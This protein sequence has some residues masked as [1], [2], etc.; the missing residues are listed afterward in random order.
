MKALI[1]DNDSP[2]SARLVL[3]EIPQPRPA[4]GE[5]LVR[6][7]AAGLNR[8]DLALLKDHYTGNAIG[9]SEMAGVVV[10][11]AGCPGYTVGDR[12][13]ALSK[14]AHAEYACVDHRLAVHVPE[15]VDWPTAASL[16][17][18][19]MTAHDAV[20]TQG[21][22]CAGETVLVQG[23][24]SGVGQ[25][26]ARLARLAG[27][28]VVIGAGRSAAKLEQLSEDEVTHRLI[29][30]GDWAARAQE[31]TTGRGVDLVIDMVGGGSLVG[32]LHSLAVR[33]RIVAVGRLG[34]QADMLDIG[35]LAHKRAQLIGVTFRTR[36][37]DE[38]SQIARA[39]A[40]AVLPHV[41]AGRIRPRLD[42]I[43]PLAEIAAAQELM[44]RNEHFG[45]VVLAIR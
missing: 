1:V 32:N 17:A 15:N 45:K 25:A 34:G 8:A 4:V 36:S 27:A 19:Y 16:P 22:L 38:K 24:T 5:L 23:V 26:A 44:R 29:T 37:I 31:L 41:V 10:E 28:R 40:D 42:R 11:A 35:M 7:E 30:D 39:F 13:M 21:R 43:Y 9:G 20:F 33:G 14:G 3:S 18:W 6:V 2:A 12:V